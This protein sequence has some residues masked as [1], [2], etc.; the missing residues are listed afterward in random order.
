MDIKDFASSFQTLL[1]QESL[2]LISDTSGS[3]SVDFLKTMKAAI[4]DAVD[5]G[6]DL[7]PEVLG[8]LAMLEEMEE[9]AMAMQ[10]AL[11]AG[12]Y[13]EAQALSEDVA[14][15]SGVDLP[16]YEPEPELFEAIDAQ[17][18][19]AVLTC[20]K[21]VD[22]NYGHG[23]YKKTALYHAVAHLNEEP[24]F[25]VINALLDAGADPQQGLGL[26]TN[27]LHGLGFGYYQ[28]KHVAPLTD[29]VKRCVALGADLEQRSNRLNWTPLHTALNEWNPPVAAALLAAGA[30]PNASTNIDDIGCTAG[31]TA[32][33]MAMCHPELIDLLLSNGA[34]PELTVDDGLTLRQ[35]ITM[36][37]EQNQNTEFAAELR[38]SLLVLDRYQSKR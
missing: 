7:P 9:G 15:L 18:F 1:E 11:D 19:Q 31:Q 4:S 38:E 34:D 13:D 16:Q 35:M 28:P 36:Q 3:G 23:S 6:V 17:D 10:S 26:E 29:F 30:N 12:N 32:L 24:S 25:E 21:A 5:S 2:K 27:V 22:V 33:A 37:I 20:L 14:R 8:Q